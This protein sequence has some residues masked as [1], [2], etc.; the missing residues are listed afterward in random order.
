[1]KWGGF[2]LTIRS[3]EFTGQLYF[4]NLLRDLHPHF[5]VP[6]FGLWTGATTFSLVSLREKSNS[7]TLAEVPHGTLCDQS[8]PASGIPGPLL[9]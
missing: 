8:L 6:E 4:V 3:S 1:M 5:H 9:L 7:G 2:F